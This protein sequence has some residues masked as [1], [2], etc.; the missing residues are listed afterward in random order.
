M[1]ARNRGLLIPR[2]NQDIL[3]TCA[4]PDLERRVGDPETASPD[5]S[6]VEKSCNFPFPR[7]PAIRIYCWTAEEIEGGAHTAEIY[8]AG[9]FTASGSRHVKRA[10][11][12]VNGDAIER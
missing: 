9:K 5:D 3:A 1:S 6:E 11:K 8:D 4:L 7:E 12:G 10:S 2:E